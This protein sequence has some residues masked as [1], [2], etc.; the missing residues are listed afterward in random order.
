MHE[1]GN[2]H[3]EISTVL[4]ISRSTCYDIMQRFT[5]RGD[6]RDTPSLGRPRILNKRGDHEVVRLLYAP[7]NGTIVAVDRKL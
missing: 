7:S 5:V 3:S 1:R 6:L 4:D 2:L